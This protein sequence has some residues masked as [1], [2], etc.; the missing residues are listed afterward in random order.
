MQQK[1]NLIRSLSI[2]VRR[3]C[4]KYSLANELECMK[5]TLRAKGYS[6]RVMV[7][8][9]DNVKRQKVIMS[10]PLEGETIPAQMNRMLTQ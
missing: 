2:R 4:T 7:A 3:I 8:R 1:R 10:L 9:V 5:Q 6:Q